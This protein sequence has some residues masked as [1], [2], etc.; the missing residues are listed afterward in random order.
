[1]ASKPKE[2]SGDNDLR[3]LID[4]T[5]TTRTLVTHFQSSLAPLT[6]SATSTDGKL[7]ASTAAEQPN[8][9]DAVKAATTLLR[10]HT[11]TLS[12][13]LLTPPLT[14][15]ALI[16][17]IGEVSSGVLTV[18]V[19]AASSTPSAG[20]VDEL[21]ILMRNELR[22]QVR[23]LLGTWNDVLALI[24]RFAEE[25]EKTGA[26]SKGKDKGPS[27]SEKQDVLATTG[28]VW[29][30]CDALL[31]L[32]A[33]GVV[34]LVVKKAEE[35]RE[36][37]MDAVEE[38][39][40]WGED[41]DDDDDDKAEGSDDE[42][43]FGDDDMFGAE[44]K[45]T[46][47]DKELKELLDA[48]VKKLKLVGT[49]YKAL[50]KRRLKTFP[51]GAPSV[52][53]KSEPASIKKL[54]GLMAILKSIPENVDDLANAFYEKDEDEAKDILDKCSSEAKS[55]IGLVR[56]SWTGKEDEFTTWSKKWV[57]ALEAA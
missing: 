48:S 37:L 54:E 16:K 27:E 8:T 31:K 15:S 4:L 20:Q 41:V 43:D 49:L 50:S 53:D 56:Q 30:T 33:D 13:L 23:R 34:G 40:E 52:E 38:L 5:N 25:R 42:D 44:N 14:P 22:A 19:A 2:K 17:K 1:M 12:L 11:T 47:A 55:A 7:A 35:W 10:S 39:K 24:L 29:E 9:L 3:T 26:K 18:L 45:L 21:G 51:M 28:V 36:V 57:T 32:C 6:A 46:K